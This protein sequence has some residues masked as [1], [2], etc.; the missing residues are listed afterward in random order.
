[1]YQYEK[2]MESIYLKIDKININNDTHYIKLINRLNWDLNEFIK[3]EIKLEEEYKT[4]YNMNLKTQINKLIEYYINIDV[5][6]K[7]Y[8]DKYM[9]MIQIDD[10]L[11]EIWN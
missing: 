5:R 7:G 4:I 10:E 2:R 9:L 1:M 6:K 11:S 3:N 8:R